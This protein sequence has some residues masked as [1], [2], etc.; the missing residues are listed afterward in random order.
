MPAARRRYAETGT[1]TD[2]TVVKFDALSGAELWRRTIKG[3]PNDR[4]EANVVT[5]DGAGDLVVA[6]FT[7]NTGT[8]D[9][10]A[11]VRLRGTDG[12]DTA[13]KP[14]VHPSTALR[15]NG[16][17]IDNVKNSPFMLSWSKH[18]MTLFRQNPEV[19]SDAQ[20]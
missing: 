9:G 4:D 20:R 10:F 19:T 11:V 17:E 18:A 13:E 8:F 16:N 5:V 12:S 15:V 2:L 3:T 14:P 1:S 6:G 7:T